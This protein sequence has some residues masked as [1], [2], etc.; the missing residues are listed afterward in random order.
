M[1]PQRYEKLIHDNIK[2]TYQKT[3][4]ETKQIIDSEARSIASTFELSDRIEQLAPKEAFV[5]IK[6]HKPNFEILC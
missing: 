4:I 2:T 5:T 1:T 3:G 6:D